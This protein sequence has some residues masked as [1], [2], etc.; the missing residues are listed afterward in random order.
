MPK[1]NSHC[2]TISLNKKI[3]INIFNTMLISSCVQLGVLKPLKNQSIEFASHLIFLE[4]WT[5]TGYFL[6]RYSYNGKGR[7]LILSSVLKSFVGIN[8]LF[9]VYWYAHFPD[10]IF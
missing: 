10:V 4:T 7:C 1:L 5:K 6:V 8:L 3:N 9:L 2:L